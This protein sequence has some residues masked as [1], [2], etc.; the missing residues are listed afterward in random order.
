MLLTLKPIN[1][2]IPSRIVSYRLGGSAF[3]FSVYPLVRGYSARAEKA[4]RSTLK[5]KKKVE[6][7]LHRIIG[8]SKILSRL[9]KNPKFA[10]YFD[11]LSEAGVTSTVT[12]FLV[13]H[14]LT[15]IVPL[16]GLWWVL[17]QLDLPDQYEL[18]LYFTDLLDRCGEAMEK[19]VGDKYSEGLDRNRLILAGAISYALVKMLYPVRVLISLWAAPYFG[20]WLLSPINMLR[21]KSR[22]KVGS[23]STREPL[24]K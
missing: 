7:R 8:K 19:L 24:N 12:S 11:R 23:G 9:N 2:L 17:Y 3:R 18:P 4:Q 5:D 13:L 20:R 21:S 14:E 1:V 16:F 6:D 10:G 15:A 22:I